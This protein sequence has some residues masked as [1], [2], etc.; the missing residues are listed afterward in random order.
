LSPLL[1][2]EPQSWLP[3]ALATEGT[4]GERIR[5]CTG[6]AAAESDGPTGHLIGPIQLNITEATGAYRKFVGGHHMVDIL[7]NSPDGSF[8]EDFFCSISVK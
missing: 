2:T 5:V 8:V 1:G 3:W 4:L 6:E 7:R